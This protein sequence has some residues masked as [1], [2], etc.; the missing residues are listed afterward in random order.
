MG[1]RQRITNVINKEIPGQPLGI[2][3]YLM[4][5]RT[6]MKTKICLLLL[7]TGCVFSQTPASLQNEVKRLYTAAHDIDITTLSEMLCTTDAEAYAKLDGHFQNE[8]QKFRYVFTNAKYNY[9]P[10]KAIDGK[11]YY[12]ITFRNV[13]RV[14]YFK[15]IDI[16]STQ[17]LLKEKFSA[18]T[19]TYDKN[20]NAYM[21]TYNAKMVAIEDSG[22]KFAFVD[23]TFPSV[24][25]N[26]LTD[27][28]KKELGL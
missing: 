16:A 13:V 2:F 18:E 24:S 12:L 26:C 5:K 10:G 4:S 7:I 20:R 22:W 8:E 6:N 28:I 9:G 15:P 1:C 14:T 25:E 27:N 21:I 3:L 23:N 19:I 11:T 17:A